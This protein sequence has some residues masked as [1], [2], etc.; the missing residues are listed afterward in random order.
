MHAASTEM[1]GVWQ[2]CHL[3]FNTIPLWFCPDLSF[4]QTSANQHVGL[5]ASI[6]CLPL[7][8]QP[9]RLDKARNTNN[10][11]ILLC[12]YFSPGNLLLVLLSDTWE[13]KWMFWFYLTIHPVS[14]TIGSLNSVFRIPHGYQTQAIDIWTHYSDNN[15]NV[16]INHNYKVIDCFVILICIRIVNKIIVFHVFKCLAWLVLLFSNWYRRFS[17]EN[18]LNLDI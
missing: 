13:T 15:P 17:A 6:S 7:L 16:D 11:L 10:N 14:H 9:Q 12:W 8:I 4:Q 5:I 18:I 3:W 2:Y 1:I